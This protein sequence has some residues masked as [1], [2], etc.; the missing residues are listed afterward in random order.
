MPYEWL[1]TEGEAPADAGAFSSRRGGVLHLW[2]HRSLSKRGFV[3][4]I[5]AT[6]ALLLL[7]MV[8]LLGSPIVWGLLPF[9]M[10]ALALL[11]LMMQ[12]NYRDGDLLEELVLAPDRVALT[13]H[14]PRGRRREWEANPHWVRVSLHEEDGPVPN[15]VTL[16]GAGREVEIGAFLSA[17]ERRALYE[18]L[19][20]RLPWRGP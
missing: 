3:L 9:L 8:A 1:T 16:R 12:R 11:Y 2:P 19:S 17:E 6:F 13:R 4:F 7:P 20:G 15:Y 18:D 5:G 14:E 10:G